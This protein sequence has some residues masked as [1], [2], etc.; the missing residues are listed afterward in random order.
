MKKLWGTLAALLCL[1]VLLSGCSRDMNWVIDNEP[2]VRGIVEEVGEDYVLIRAAEADAPEIA[3]GGLVSADLATRLQD[4]KFSA[5][6]GDE[7]A[8]YYDS[9]SA[10]VPG[11]VPEIHDVHGYTLI[12]P[13]G[14]MAGEAR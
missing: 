1:T 2:S 13:A 9:G 11:T 14:R 6:V 7:V 8:V 4:C 12:T 5:Q 10:V 3:K